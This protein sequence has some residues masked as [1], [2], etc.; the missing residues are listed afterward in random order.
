AASGNI[1]VVSIDSP[2]IEKIGVWPWPRNL[3]AKLIEKLESAGVEDI[4][5]DVDFS[6]PS[7]QSS[8]DAFS[9]ALQKAGGSIVLP[10]FKQKVHESVY[11]NRPLPRFSES[12]WTALVNVAADRDGVVRRYPIGDAVDGSILPSM[13]TI[14]AGRSKSNSTSFWIDFS[15]LSDSIPTVSYVDVLRDDT[16][17]LQ[18]FRNKKVI[19]GGTAL[20]LGDRFAI[21]QGRIISGPLL[22]ALAAESIL[23][24]RDLVRVS[25]PFAMSGAGILMLC[26][27]VLWRRLSAWWRAVLL[28]GVAVAAEAA[29]TVVQSKIPVVFDTSIFHVATAGYLLAITLDEIDFRGMLSKIADS[30][31]EHIAMSLGDGLVCTDSVGLIT[32]W[33]PGATRIFGYEADEMIGRPIGNILNSCGDDDAAFLLAE[34]PQA[35]LHSSCG[36]V[37][38]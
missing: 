31:F 28:V 7:N 2:S 23:Q 15:I 17:A 37:L 18:S 32:V 35:D 27:I 11:I 14:L 25:G 5:F 13:A 9:T 38:E 16:S 20:E 36:R 21:P 1:V 33:N 34:I 30:R 26:M 3:H 12:S 22:Q 19:V 8:D 6:S 24:G 4:A 10:A 29:A